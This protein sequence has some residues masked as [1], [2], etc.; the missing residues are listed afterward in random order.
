[1]GHTNENNDLYLNAFK[2]W[3]FKYKIDKAY[4]NTTY[5]IRQK[6]DKKNAEFYQDI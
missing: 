4:G 2:V 5:A 3:P 6:Q 1:M